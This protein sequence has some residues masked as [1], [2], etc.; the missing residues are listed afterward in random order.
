MADTEIART[1][2]E[3]FQTLGLGVAF[4][5]IG[6]GARVIIG[7][8]KVNDTASAPGSN[9]TVKDLIEPSRLLISLMIGAIAGALAAATTNIDL[10]Q[11]IPVSLLM[12]LAAAGYAGSDFIEGLMSRFKPKTDDAKPAPATDVAAG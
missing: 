5:L 6:Q 10:S 1:A 8:K 12:G 4:G 9:A 11:K 3:W 2:V 7:L